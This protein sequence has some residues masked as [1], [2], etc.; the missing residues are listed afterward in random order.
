[1]ISCELITHFNMDK[2]TTFYQGLSKISKALSLMI[3]VL[4]GVNSASAQYCSSNAT[5][6]ADEDIYS[7]YLKGNTVTLN[8]VSSTPTCQTYTD[9]T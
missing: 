9:F 2:I 6:T 3:I 1:M 5:S 7:V 4:L 8:N